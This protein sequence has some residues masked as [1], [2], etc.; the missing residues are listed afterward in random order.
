MKLNRIVYL[1]F[2]AS[3]LFVSATNAQAQKTNSEQPTKKLTASKAAITKAINAKKATIDEPKIDTRPKIEPVVDD[4]IIDPIRARWYHS[5]PREP[6]WLISA[7]NGTRS[8]DDPNGLATWWHDDNPDAV[9]NFMSQIMEGYGHGA[10]RFFVNRPMGT[11]GLSHVSAASWLTLPPSKRSALVDAL[12]DLNLNPNTD[13]IHIFW[14]IGSNLKDPRSAA[15][16]N[17]DGTDYL[18]GETDTWEH[19]ITS[20][21]ILGGWASTGASGLFID[22]SSSVDERQHFRFLSRQLLQSPFE[23]IIGGEAFPL[24]LDGRG[25][26]LHDADNNSPTLDQ[27][28]VG[29][30][31]WVGTYSYIQHPSR[32]PQG[33]TNATWPPNAETSRMFCWFNS[34]KALGSDSDK[35]GI[36]ELTIRDGLIPITNDA[37]MF[38]HA[39]TIWRLME[40]IEDDVVIDD[41]S[42]DPMSRLSTDPRSRVRID[43]KVLFCIVG[44]T[45]QWNDYYYE[46]GVVASGLAEHAEYILQVGSRQIGCDGYPNMLARDSDGVFLDLDVELYT[47]QALNSAVPPRPFIG[48]FWDHEPT[49]RD[50][51]T[52]RWLH[53]WPE[54]GEYTQVDVDYHNQVIETMRDELGIA[55]SSYA[56]PRHP[57]RGPVDFF[58]ISKMATSI[59]MMENADWV[60]MNYYPHPAYNGLDVFDDAEKAL[61]RQSI[62]KSIE[63]FKAMFPGKQIVPFFFLRYGHIANYELLEILLEEIDKEPQ[64]TNVAIWANPHSDFKWKGNHDTSI[65][66]RVYKDKLLECAPLL[67]D[68][69]NGE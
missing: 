66:A 11:D 54:D 67:L 19:L 60:Q 20:R 38:S 65:M 37:G 51:E 39:R 32:W 68:W 33:T 25:K 27:D 41:D 16:W 48:A 9:Q 30:M 40:G 26:T 23:M 55:I 62:I 56:V 6:M 64:I 13:P 45:Q 8:D 18:L 14:F 47:D 29:A 10:R 35:R 15:G 63:V 17:E 57:K 31:S 12:I 49:C 3:L 50:D 61:A 28:S 52:N 7:G 43:R 36:I 5:V 44:N 21:N 53:S 59:P 69:V 1:I 24:A 34:T 2:A 46:E 22:H 4:P 42:V 58:D